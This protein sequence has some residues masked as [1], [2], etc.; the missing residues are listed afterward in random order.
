MNLNRFNNRHYK[1]NLQDRT[2]LQR[3]L[4]VYESDEL[5]E[6]CAGAW[7]GIDAY[8]FSDLV[9]SFLRVSMTIIG[10]FG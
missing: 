5:T 3:I 10:R 7:V 9:A 4:Q 8:M 2:I 6:L 1:I